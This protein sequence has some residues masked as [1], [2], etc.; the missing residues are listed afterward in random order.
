MN[1]KVECQLCKNFFNT[2]THSHLAQKHNISVEDYL[3][4]FPNSKMSW[5]K[6]VKQWEN[7]KHP[8]KGKKMPQ[9]E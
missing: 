4:K 2:I 8:N 3:K 5:N 6:G 9:K 7:N 1:K